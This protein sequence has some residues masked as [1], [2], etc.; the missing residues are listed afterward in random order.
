ML[1]VRMCEST[2]VLPNERVYTL[3][4]IER[5]R[6]AV[7][8]AF[9]FGD[10]RINRHHVVFYLF[11]Y[12]KVASY[13]VFY[14]MQTAVMMVGMTV[15]VVVL[16]FVVML[17]VVM[18]FV[19]MMMFMLVVMLML[20][21]MFMLVAMLMLVMVVILM[22]VVVVMLVMVMSLMEI[23]FIHAVYSN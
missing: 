3:D 20:M 16:V 15:F 18:M 4:G 12:I 11:G 2:D 1:M 21:M 6:H 14:I 23:L 13:D 7:C 10:E 5:Y 17:V 9:G 19:V 8:V 22:L